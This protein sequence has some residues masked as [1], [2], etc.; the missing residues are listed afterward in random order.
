MFNDWQKALAA[1]DL[2]LNASPADQLAATARITARHARDKDDLALLLDAIGLPTDEDTVTALLP[3][4]PTRADTATT[5]DEP[6][7]PQTPNPPS[8]PSSPSAH[9][10]VALS[11]SYDDAYSVADIVKATGLS[12]DEI[13]ALVDA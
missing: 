7:M 4:L 6:E 12:E 10:A 3:H 11:M 1:E 2:P 5:G 13:K 9:E 8:N